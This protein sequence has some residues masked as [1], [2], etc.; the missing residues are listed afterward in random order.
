MLRCSA[1]AVHKGAAV[2]GSCQALWFVLP[3]VE[4]M[5]ESPNFRVTQHLYRAQHTW[6]YVDCTKFLSERERQFSWSS[7]MCN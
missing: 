1:A 2:Q 6:L 5:S 7:L 3:T 4:N